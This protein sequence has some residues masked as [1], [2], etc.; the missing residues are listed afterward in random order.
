MDAFAVKYPRFGA[1]NV[2]F[3]IYGVKLPIK[4]SSSK[5]IQKEFY[6]GWTSGNYISNVFMLDPDRCI[7]E[8]VIN[9]PGSMH[10]ST[11]MEVREMYELLKAIHKD[12][13]V[14]FCVDS[15]FCARF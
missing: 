11:V 12:H 9:A 1:L 14:A 10:D 7:W 2:A 8:I 13:R 3:T 5:A 15:A 6:N 4:K